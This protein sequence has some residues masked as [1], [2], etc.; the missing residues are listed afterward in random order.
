MPG[1][2]TY[3]ALHI[4]EMS[5]EANFTNLMGYD[6]AGGWDNVT[7]HQANIYPANCSR[8]HF[9]TDDAVEYYLSQVPD[10][11]KI[12]LG[13]PLYGRAFT[14]TEGLGK[15]FNGVGNA[16]GN[17]NW[18]NGVWDYKAL[19][20]PGARE[21]T[22]KSAGASYS[23]DSS[24]RV[25]ISYDNPEIARQKAEYIVSKNLGGRMWWESSADKKGDGS[26]I[27]AVS[28]PY[29]SHVPVL[30]DPQVVKVF[31]ELEQTQNH[32]DYPDSA[33]ENLRNQ[34]Q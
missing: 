20:Q 2:D 33:Y 29:N 31:L 19:P 24:R 1:P 28:D 10:S 15:H 6:Y 18:E 22:D 5:A 16:T 25:L 26:L 7:C 8:T 32:L 21:F 3:K 12:V 34:F 23:Y 27:D 9:N 4:K 17:G 11:S 13:M 30:R 14:D